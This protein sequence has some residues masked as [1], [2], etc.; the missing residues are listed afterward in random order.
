M[1]INSSITGILLMTLLVYTIAR[2]NP[3]FATAQNAGS[4]AAPYIICKKTELM[5]VKYAPTGEVLEK[6]VYVNFEIYNNSSSSVN[7][8]VTDR[9]MCINSSTLSTLYG[10]PMPTE[11]ES[12]G[13]LTKITWKNV[14]ADAGKNIRYQYTAE[15]LRTEPI[16][17]NTTL[18]VNNKSANITKS[19]NTYLTNVNLSDT[20]TFLLAVTNAQQ[21]LYIADE[22]TAVQPLLCTTSVPLS[23]DHFS[24]M[25]TS[26][27][28]NS[29]S[30][31]GGKT[32]TTWLT[33]LS[34]ESQTFEISA[35]VADVGSWGEISIDPITIQISSSSEALKT[36]F[37]GMISSLDF[38]ID[39]MENFIDSSS[40]LSTQTFQIHQAIKEI[41]NATA[42][43]GNATVLVETLCLIS[44]SLKTADSL[45]EMAQNYAVLA[46]LSLT[47]FLNDTRTLIFLGNPANSNL[48]GYLTDAIAN[49]TMAYELINMTR[50]GNATVPGL[51][52]LAN[53]TYKIAQTINS[54]GVILGNVTEQLYDVANGLHLISNATD[55]TKAELEQSLNELKTEKSRIED[56][57]LTFD[58]KATVPFDLE[59]RRSKADS[60][61]SQPAI[62]RVNS[63][64]W[65]VTNITMFNP[66]NY[67]RIIY[68]L[69]IQLKLEDEPLNPFVEV[70]VE[71][72]WESPSSVA[73]LRLVYNSSTKTLCSWP[74][75]KIDANSVS[76][77]LVDWAER[78]MRLLVNCEEEPQIV[79][80]LDVAD[81][82]NCVKI[83]FTEGQLS[84][85]VI[86]PQ[87]IVQ[88][89]T[90]PPPPPIPPT[91]PKNLA[92][93]II[94]Y[95]QKTEIQL[96]ILTVVAI[97]AVVYGVLRER[98]KEKITAKRD[99]L[100]RKIETETLLKEI[101]KVNRILQKE[102]NSS[103]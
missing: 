44:L 72:G 64:V 31:F 83:D 51:D 75:M 58:S 34:N 98:R 66:A 103:N 21:P 56:I 47:A 43:L 80:E 49:M 35:N 39:L 46:N 38:S 40:K 71:G 63:T 2:F 78:P 18:L 99:V 84:C 10:T 54:T 95:L 87:L 41:A 93:L 77:V 59:I 32:I 76:N 96:S 1:K 67:S 5:E 68:K 16:M 30:T 25:K 65:K 89:Y 7:L 14:T 102:E 100:T 69:S 19:K 29:T 26:P 50:Y 15:S 13:N 4:Q 79:Y 23:N 8:N 70:Y 86:Q 101:D 90:A 9:V 22:R 42:E 92:E 45:L 88:N 97:I 52:Q 11:F 81:M 61:T 57:L 60:C 62:E 48:T 55:Q 36:Y 17:V 12:F 37:Q 94:E 28:A 3:S 85:S 53:M 73:Q 91:P 74:W 33:F 82:Q 6:S 20:V 24:G 27:K